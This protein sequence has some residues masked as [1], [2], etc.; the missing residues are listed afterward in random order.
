MSPLEKSLKQLLAQQRSKVEE[1][2][3]KTNFYSTKN[4]IERYDAT[5]A[6][7]PARPRPVGPQGP[8]GPLATPQRQ[9]KGIVPNANNIQTPGQRPTG[10]AS[11]PAQRM[12]EFCFLQCYTDP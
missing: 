8:Q 4:L 5:P 7:S 12:F 11:G 2:K 10:Q 9:I 6:D 3:K 1:I